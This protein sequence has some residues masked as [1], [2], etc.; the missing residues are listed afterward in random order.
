MLSQKQKDRYMLSNV[1]C[2]WFDF[3]DNNYYQFNGKCFF[4]I[5]YK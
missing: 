3:Q 5:V 4:V 1:K 2:V